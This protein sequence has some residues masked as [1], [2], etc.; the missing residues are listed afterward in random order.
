MFKSKPLEMIL[1]QKCLEQ[2]SL[3]WLWPC[4]PIEIGQVGAHLL[5]ELHL[6]I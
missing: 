4:H 5:D 2:A 3:N 1:T 6:L